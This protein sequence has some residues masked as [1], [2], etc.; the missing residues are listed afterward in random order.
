MKVDKNP[1]P[2]IYEFKIYHCALIGVL[3]YGCS[4]NNNSFVNNRPNIILLVCD[5][6]GFGDLGSFGH[7]VIKTPN[8]DALFLGGIKLTSL[9][10]AATV[11]SPSRVG[12]LTGRNPN[13]AGVYDWIPEGN[14]KKDDLRDLVHM[15]SSEVTIASLLKS[16][17]YETCLVGK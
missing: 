7:L 12:L 13:R 14:K 15:R 9:Y 5:D 1:N 4:S 6:L 11:C 17:A 2:S 3:F 16:A 8:L 10:A